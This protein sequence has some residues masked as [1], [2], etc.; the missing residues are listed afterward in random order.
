MIKASELRVKNLVWSVCDESEYYIKGLDIM[1]LDQ[2]ADPYVFSAIPITEELLL[3]LG[4]EKTIYTHE[5]KEHC[6]T[7]KA[8]CIDINLD[9][10][11]KGNVEVEITSSRF[12]NIGPIDDSVCCYPLK[13][14][15][16]IHQLQNLY[17][18]LTGTE[19]QLNGS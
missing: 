7:E 3:R 10:G 12:L 9:Y 11:Q 4:I 17:F 14:V 8:L 1:C 19:L 6:N 5:I 16:S 13:Q 15:K 18:A 2:G